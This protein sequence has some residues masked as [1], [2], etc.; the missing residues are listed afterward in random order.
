VLRNIVTKLL[1][2][3]YIH[4][5]AVSGAECR[6]R[7]YALRCAIYVNEHFAVSVLLLLMHKQ[8]STVCIYAFMV[9]AIYTVFAFYSDL[10]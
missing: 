8:V 5:T 7:N 6:L 9:T 4:L 3:A 1:Q 10:Q 2:G